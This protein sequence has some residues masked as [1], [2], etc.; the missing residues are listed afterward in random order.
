MRGDTPLIVEDKPVTVNNSSY[1]GYEE[2]E[3][4]GSLKASG[5]D[6]GGAANH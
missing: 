3:I 1:G 5:G 6:R 2:S 4:S